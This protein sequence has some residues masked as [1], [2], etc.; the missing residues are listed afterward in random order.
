[1]I[2]DVYRREWTPSGEQ[3]LAKKVKEKGGTK[4]VEN[5]DA[6]LSELAGLDSGN[7]S[8]NKVKPFYYRSARHS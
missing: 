4:L 6:V 2:V 1:M 8:A 3:Q 7:G 5:S